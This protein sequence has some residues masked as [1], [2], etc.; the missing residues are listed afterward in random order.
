MSTA[1]ACR[2]NPH[3]KEHHVHVD[4]EVLSEE[5]QTLVARQI[6]FVPDRLTALDSESEQGVC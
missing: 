6:H 3:F 2:V 4:A 5:E 1:G